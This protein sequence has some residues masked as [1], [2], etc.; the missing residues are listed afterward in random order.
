MTSSPMSFG[1]EHLKIQHPEEEIND[2][3]M[4]ALDGLD[5]LSLPLQFPDME[6]V[7]P[8]YGTAGKICGSEGLKLDKEHSQK[9]IDQQQPSSDEAVEVEEFNNRTT[10]GVSVN[11]SPFLLSHNLPF[12]LLR[13]P[14]S[15]LYDYNDKPEI[16]SPV[17]TMGARVL[18]PLGLEISFECGGNFGSASPGSIGSAR[19]STFIELPI[20]VDP[21]RASATAHYHN[22]IG[23]IALVDGAA[24]LESNA[25][26]RTIND[27]SNNALNTNNEPN[28]I[29]VNININLNHY[30][31]NTAGSLDISSSPRSPIHLNLSQLYYLDEGF[32]DLFHAD[33]AND[34]LDT[35]GVGADLLLEGWMVS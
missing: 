17:S 27:G 26:H 18:D 7:W 33:V 31:L 4:S 34:D 25:S 6:K 23:Q 30:G 21:N 12:G 8:G 5:F 28:F 29:N 22:M 13:S 9:I 24:S 16:Y 10:F 32:A 20:V 11:G 19:S 1:S 14:T 3:S 15:D 35:D 2:Q